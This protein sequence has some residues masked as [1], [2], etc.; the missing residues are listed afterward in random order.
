MRRKN[1]ERQKPEASGNSTTIQT[2]DGLKAI[3]EHLRHI[4]RL[5]DFL[6]AMTR[7]IPDIPLSCYPECLV[8]QWM[9]SENVLECA[10]RKLLKTVCLRCEDFHELA[11]QSVLITKMDTPEPIS[12]V[13]Q[14]ARDFEN[15]SNRFQRA[16]ADL[17]VECRLNQ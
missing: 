5:K 16:L 13:I 3:Q 2:F 12:D 8:A 17:H 10:N 11:A 14:A 7:K 6:C 4:A 9:H 1:R 15:A